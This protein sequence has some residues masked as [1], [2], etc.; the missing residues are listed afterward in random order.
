MRTKVRPAEHEVA[1]IAGRQHGVITL[2]QLLAAGL[3]RGVLKRRVVCPP[4]R[5]VI[6]WG[7]SPV[8]V[9]IASFLLALVVLSVVV[10]SPV[11]AVPV[12]L[13]GAGVLG[14]ADFRRRRKQA[15][16]LQSFREEAKA[17][18]IEF[19]E[20]DRETLVSE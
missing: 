6:I 20:R 11:V 5:W 1:R 19:T 12:V 15:G 14:A 18:K 10:G 9:I 8:T 16:Q 2:G 4:L 7:M 17:E 3:T 13:V